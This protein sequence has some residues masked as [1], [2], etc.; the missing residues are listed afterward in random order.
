MQLGLYTD[1]LER[2][3]FLAGRRAFIW[4]VH[5]DGGIY[6]IDEPVGQSS[7]LSLW[8]DYRKA[9]S[10]AEHTVGKSEATSPAGSGDCKLRHW[11]NIC[12]ERMLYRWES[13]NGFRSWRNGINTPHLWSFSNHYAK[14]KF[15]ADNVW[16]PNVVSKQCGAAV[17]LRVLVDRKLIRLE[18]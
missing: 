13:Y 5:G 18:A 7:Q 10:T 4:D 17:L 16:D 12:L 11:Y 1:I 15:I 3:G 9:L 6:N 14:G 2:K 8:D